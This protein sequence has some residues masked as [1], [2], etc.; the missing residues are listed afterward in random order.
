MPSHAYRLFAWAIENH[1]PL[2]CRYKGMVREFC[3]ITLGIDDKGEVAHVWVPGE[4]Q[5]REEQ[6]QTDRRKPAE[7]VLRRGAGREP[8][9]EPFGLGPGSGR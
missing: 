1:T 5:D 4:D 8:E 2:R 9:L 3:P 6:A 7:A